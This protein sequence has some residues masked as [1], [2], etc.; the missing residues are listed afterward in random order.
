MRFLNRQAPSTQTFLLRKGGNKPQPQDLPDLKLQT[1]QN[2]T[3]RGEVRQELI[4]LKS[5]VSWQGS[6]IPGSSYGFPGI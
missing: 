4:D 2:G 1:S 6:I 5:R 3:F